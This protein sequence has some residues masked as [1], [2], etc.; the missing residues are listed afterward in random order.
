M[1]DPTQWKCP[2]CDMDITAIASEVTH[3][4]PNNKNQYTQFEKVEK[5]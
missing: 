4:C 3:R 1:S 2:K 5:K